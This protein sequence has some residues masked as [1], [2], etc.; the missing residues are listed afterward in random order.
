MR[1]YELSDQQWDASRFCF[2]SG[3]A[4]VRWAARQVT[5][6]R[7]STG[8]FGSCTPVRP[9]VTSPSPTD[10]GKPCLPDSTDGGGMALGFASSPRSWTNWTTANST[11]THGASTVPSS[12][13]VGLPPE[14]GKRGAARGGWGHGSN[15]GH[16][17]G[18]AGV[19]ARRATPPDPRLVRWGLA[20]CCQL[21]P[22]HPAALVTRVDPGVEPCLIPCG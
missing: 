5:T 6:A 18:V 1:R 10:H 11:T 21:D 20:R 4:P 13:P 7:S 12:G 8:S 19:D 22:S 17:S 2:L 15:A 14:G 16:S 3:P 9:G